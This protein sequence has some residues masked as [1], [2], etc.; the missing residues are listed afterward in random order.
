MDLL[1]RLITDIISTTEHLMQADPIDLAAFAPGATSIEKAR[2]SKGV[3]G[4]NRHKAERPMRKGVH[5]T[6]C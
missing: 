3:D 5:R 2:M 4:R 1:D 6:V